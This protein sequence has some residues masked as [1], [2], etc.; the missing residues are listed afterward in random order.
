MGT[1]VGGGLPGRGV[2]GNKSAA[3]L[4]SEILRRYEWKNYALVNN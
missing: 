1:V 2:I 4:V 3:M